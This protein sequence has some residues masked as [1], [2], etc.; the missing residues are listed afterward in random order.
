[1]L[2]LL[3]DEVHVA[4]NICADSSVLKAIRFVGYLLTIAKLFVPLIIVGFGVFD[5][6]K[7]IVSAENTMKKQLKSIGFRVIIGLLIFFIPTF[8]DVILSGLTNF[9]V[10]AEDYRKC[11]V[12]LLKPFDCSVTENGVSNDPEDDPSNNNSNNNA[13]N[14]SNNGQN[15]NNS[16]NTGNNNSNNN[17][18]SSSSEKKNCNAYTP[19]GGECPDVD[20]YGNTCEPSAGGLK[21]KIKQ[22]GGKKSCF[23]YN[24]GR[25]EDCP[26]KDELGMAC[27]F[28]DGKCQSKLFSSP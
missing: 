5:L 1:M 23:D 15:G 16:N 24:T 20:D 26:E 3:L 14:S 27:K 28:E 2:N 22:I 10:L 21:C 17:N 4:D 11:E 12:C 8:V 19:I 7:S 18:N 13:N 6:Y 9:N 25:E